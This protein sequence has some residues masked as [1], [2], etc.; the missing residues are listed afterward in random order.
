MEPQLYRSEEEAA[1]DWQEH[2]KSE[3]PPELKDK[4]GR[5]FSPFSDRAIRVLV[6]FANGKIIAAPMSG[7]VIMQQVKQWSRESDEFKD[8]L[9]LCQAIGG[10]VWD[11]RVEKVKEERA[12]YDLVL[13]KIINE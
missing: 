11:A 12:R 5:T 1:P 9:R 7:G 8:A 4:I 10:A 2:L 3:V 6:E 13:E